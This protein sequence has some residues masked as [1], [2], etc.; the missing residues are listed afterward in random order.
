MMKKFK[1]SDMVWSAHI[2]IFVSYIQ[3]LHFVFLYV[4]KEY[5]SVHSWTFVV[6]NTDNMFN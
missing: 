6:V 1:S 3:I 2:E 4:M 5:N